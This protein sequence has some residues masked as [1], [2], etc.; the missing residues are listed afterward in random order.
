MARVWRP[1][2]LF[3]DLDFVVCLI[4]FNGHVVRHIDGLDGVHEGCGVGIVL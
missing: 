1:W 3:C 2:N 4:D